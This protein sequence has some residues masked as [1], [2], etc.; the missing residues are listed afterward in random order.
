MPNLIKNITGKISDNIK[1]DIKLIK[2]ANGQFGHDDWFKIG[3]FEVFLQNYKKVSETTDLNKN[4][5]FGLSANKDKE[6]I[7]IEISY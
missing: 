3:Y 7:E 6:F 2:S 1:N 4:R 5:D